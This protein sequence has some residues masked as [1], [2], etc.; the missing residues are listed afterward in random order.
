M[1]L[2]RADDD[3]A[4]ASGTLVSV[5]AGL[6]LDERRQER[7]ECETRMPG[8]SSAAIAKDH[9]RMQKSQHE[10]WLLERYQPPQS[11]AAAVYCN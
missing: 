9:V 11:L 5:V 2:R 10:C 3:S 8:H 1:T 7:T 4:R 6:I